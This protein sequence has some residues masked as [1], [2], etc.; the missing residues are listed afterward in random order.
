[1]KVQKIPKKQLKSN[2]NE[3]GLYSVVDKILGQDKR[4]WTVEGKL[5]E[6]KL[7]ELVQKDDKNIIE[8]LLSNPLTKEAFFQKVSSILV[9]K[10]DDFL[11]FKT[12]GEFLDGSYTAYS[13]HI[14]LANNF[15][16]IK[17]ASDVVLNFPYKDCILEGG[18]EKGS[19]GRDEVFY[20]KTLARE[21]VNRLE[22]EKVLINWVKY[23]DK[24]ITKIT[25]FDHEKD[26]LIMRGNNLLALY[27]L[28]PKYRGKVKLIYIDPPYNTGSDDFRYN[29]RFNHSTWLVFM[30]NRLEVAKEL[31]LTTGSIFIQV[32]DNE[33]AYLKVLCD[34]IFG[35][36]NFRSQIS[37]LRSSSGK[38]ISRN[39]PNDV[40][41]LLWYSKSEKYDFNAVYKPL[42]PG[43]IAMYNKDDGDGRGKYR[44]FPL[45]KTGGPGPETS[46]NYKDNKGKTW[47]CPAKGW[48][49]KQEK[50]KALEN[51]GRLYIDGS[52]IAEKAYW[53]ERD[54]DGK[55]ANN[56]W[57]DIY[58][59]QGSNNEKL[60]FVG[61]KPEFLIK[62]V[63]EMTTNQGDIVLDY[64]LGSGTT[65][66][67]A[68]K[69]QRR[70]I[71]I[72][73]LFYKETDPVKRLQD[74][75]GGDDNGISKEMKWKGGGSFV[76]TELAQWNDKY[77]QEIEKVKSTKDLIKIYEKINKEAF[78]IY[79][80]DSAKWD[81]KKFEELPLDNQKK[82]LIDILNMNHLYINYKDIED[83]IF[84]VSSE[85]IK[86]NKNFYE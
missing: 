55:L 76:Y 37:W 64:H 84:K 65:A 26:N 22:E 21:D 42:S 77:V 1:M 62:R 20:N 57:D 12:M 19:E 11:S 8:L 73:Q 85:D 6:N 54:N 29:D 25:S 34:E 47:N 69:M 10:K 70:W 33:Q 81:N 58:N 16:S 60:D 45:Q 52:T 36:D 15:S 63:I 83:S 49:M 53:N 82:V 30:K 28:L 74:V 38:T 80:F 3:K 41:Y 66:S 31:L 7:I 13:K 40:D 86:L 35:R 5:I 48:R 23:T 71:G 27:S 75:L 56:L 2:I 18:Q 4:L 46:Y 17:N 78:L 72:E 9:F 59:L 24:G 44:L 39:L 14:G 68:Q 61:Q 43:T 51:D 67:V 32:D 50:L 79:T